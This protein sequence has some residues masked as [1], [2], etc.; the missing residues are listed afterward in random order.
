M[1]LKLFIYD[2][3]KQYFMPYASQ[4]YSG[5]DFLWRVS[6]SAA[7]CTFATTLLTYPFDLIHTRVTSDMTK[8]GQ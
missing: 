8:K 1:T 7:L 3:A 5:F 4:R 2:K 6:A